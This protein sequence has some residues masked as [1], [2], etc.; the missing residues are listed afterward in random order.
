[1]LACGAR[2]QRILGMSEALRPLASSVGVRVGPPL[3]LQRTATAAA[4]A[5]LLGR[6]NARVQLGQL[7]DDQSGSGLSHHFT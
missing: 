6:G 4:A 3:R 2:Q 1:M 7:Q 5:G